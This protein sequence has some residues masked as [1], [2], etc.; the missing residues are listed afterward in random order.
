MIHQLS[1]QVLLPS[2]VG[3]H[4]SCI[5]WKGLSSLPLLAIKGLWELGVAPSSSYV[6]AAMLS[7]NRLTIDIIGGC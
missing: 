1:T 6:R 2:Q 5:L 3:L 4:V 7:I